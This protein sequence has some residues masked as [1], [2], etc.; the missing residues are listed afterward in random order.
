MYEQNTISDDFTI[1]QVNCTLEKSCALRKT[2][3][4]LDVR[5]KLIA[6]VALS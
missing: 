3:R 5:R 2:F 6:T 1:L 4:E